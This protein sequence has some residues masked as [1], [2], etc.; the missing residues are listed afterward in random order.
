MA[1][2]GPRKPGHP[3]ERDAGDVLAH[4]FAAAR[5]VTTSAADAIVSID[6]RNTVPLDDKQ[7]IHALAD[8]PALR[9]RRK[10]RRGSPACQAGGQI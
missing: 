2:L 6:A 4:R 7:R 3:S 8:S 5:L 1:V 10:C 9:A